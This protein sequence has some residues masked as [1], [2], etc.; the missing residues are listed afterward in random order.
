MVH[1]ITTSIYIHTYT[2]VLRTL[3]REET[4]LL[5]MNIPDQNSFNFY[6]YLINI[7]T[8][9]C[10]NHNMYVH[11]ICTDGRDGRIFRTTLDITLPLFYPVAPLHLTRI[12]E[13][14]IHFVTLS[15]LSLLFPF[16]Y[17]ISQL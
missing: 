2:V 9:K 3:E 16:A 4:T 15:P 17:I 13:D 8:Y 1:V 14:H 12:V 11:F 5:S 10:T 6:K 7:H